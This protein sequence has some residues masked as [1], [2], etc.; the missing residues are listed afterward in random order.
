MS[1][2]DAMDRISLSEF[3]DW[4]EF[5]AW[6]ADVAQHGADATRAASLDDD[7]IDHDAIAQRLNAT[8]GSIGG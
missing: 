6:R 5:F 4:M 2:A 7:E 1:V 3:H 8:L